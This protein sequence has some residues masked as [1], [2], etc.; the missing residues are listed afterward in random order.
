M[1]KIWL[2]SY[3]KDILPE[4]NNSSYTSIIDLF[5]SASD[6]FPN[7]TAFTNLNTKLTFKQTKKH[8]ENFG[9]NLHNTLSIT[10]GSK[11]AIMLPNLLTYPVALFGS[12]I[13]GEGDVSPS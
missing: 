4:I 8:A 2:K 5:K 13:A 12:Y 10:K 3:P 9:A 7:N 1:E 11:V 6:K